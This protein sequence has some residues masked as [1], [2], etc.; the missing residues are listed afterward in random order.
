MVN[1][2]LLEKN[3]PQCVREKYWLGRVHIIWPFFEGRKKKWFWCN[4][5]REGEAF[6][7]LHRVDIG[8]LV[9]GKL[10]SSADME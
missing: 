3:N 7:F 10:H 2:L 6:T 1:Y 4:G 8:T 9:V 5:K